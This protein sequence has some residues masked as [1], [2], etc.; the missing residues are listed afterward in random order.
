[1]CLRKAGHEPLLEELCSLRLLCEVVHG[2]STCVSP[3]P[4]RRVL[5]LVVDNCV[6]SKAVYTLF[7]TSP[8]SHVCDLSFLKL[9]RV[10]SPIRWVVIFIVGVM[11]CPPPPCEIDDGSP[12]QMR[13]AVRYVVA[14]VLKQAMVCIVLHPLQI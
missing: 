3:I 1:M 11:S 4:M 7:E 9:W 10:V 6:L 5:V 2:Y 13:Q 12:R 8:D 14:V